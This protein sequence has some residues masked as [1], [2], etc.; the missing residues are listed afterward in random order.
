MLQRAATYYYKRS[1]SSHLQ[2]AGSPCNTLKQHTSTRCNILQLTA[3]TNQSL[4]ICKVLQHAATHCSNAVQQDCNTL[5]NTAT[6][7]CNQSVSSHL[8]GAA[9]FCSTL[10]EHTATHC[11]TLQHTSITDQSSHICK[12]TLH[13][14]T[15]CN[16]TLQHTATHCNALQLPA[17][18]DQSPH[19]C[20]ILYIDKRACSLRIFSTHHPPLPVPSSCFRR[21]FL[22]SQLNSS[23][24]YGTVT[25][26]ADFSKFCSI[27]RIS[28]RFPHRPFLCFH[29]NSQKSAQQSSDTAL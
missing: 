7:C 19:I 24:L 4:H 14:A 17:L 23:F 29:R 16:K 28:S 22:K 18:T 25:V 12:V 8:Q 20:N 5:P 9:T 21:H 10:Q 11:N 1:V 2:G 26:R 6:H 27:F 15:Q 13:A 3:I